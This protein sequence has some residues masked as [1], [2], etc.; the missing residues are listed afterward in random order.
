[1][2]IRVSGVRRPAFRLPR[3]GRCRALAVTV[4]AAVSA[5]CA[6]GDFAPTLG[7]A[8][9]AHYASEPA[10]GASSPKGRTAE[11][12]LD[13]WWTKFASPELDAIMERGETRNLD[14]A[15]AVAQLREADAQTA[16]AGAALFPTIGYSESNTRSQSSGTNTSGVTTRP[17]IRNSFTKAVNGS[18]VLDIWGQNRAALEAAVHAATASAFDVEVVRLATRVSIVNSFLVHAANWERVAVA[19]QNLENAERVLRVIR[20]RRAAGTAADLDVAQQETLVEIQR[21][22][23]PPLRQ[24]AETS[25]SA[26]ALLLAEPLQAVEVRSKS[27][28]R[29]HLPMVAPGLPST[30]LAR[31]PDVRAAEAQLAG[32]DANVDVARKAFLPTITLTGQVG[33]QSA[34]LPLLIRPDSL[35]WSAAAGVTQPIFEG[36][37]LRAQV[38]LSEAQRE[39]L[40]EAYR[41]TIVTAFTDVEN[42]LIAI[43]ESA[44][45]EGSQRRA[46]A[47]A[48]R[49][50][51]LSEEKLRQGTIDLTTLLAT[52]NTLFQAEDAL[53]QIRLSRLQA[54]VSLFQALGGDWIDPPAGDRVA[55]C[56]RETWCPG[57]RFGRDDGTAPT[58]RQ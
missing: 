53:I 36:G 26:L 3:A 27:L 44:I 2:T 11:A 13:R 47:A 51:Q 6:T 19:G 9:P 55:T 30:L 52:Q 42:A 35:I 1:M 29:I 33:F 10:S 15:V 23:I 37:R 45:R 22:A 38:A 12:R 39:Q 54:V 41:R 16:I 49:A 7:F 43:R 50:F 57:I 4:V 40:L 28:Q 31:R 18:Y 17:S 21:A 56:G 46:V 25:R 58:T 8:V 5:G 14:I 24:A 48:R 34:L 20:Q 32:A